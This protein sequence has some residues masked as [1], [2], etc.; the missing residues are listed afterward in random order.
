MKNR[1]NKIVIAMALAIALPTIGYSE[2]NVD[3]QDI[4][5]SKKE[6]LV[7]NAIFNN[8]LW[9]THHSI[10]DEIQQ[11]SGGTFLSRILTVFAN[12]LI[13]EIA[14][15]SGGYIDPNYKN[16]IEAESKRQITAIIVPRMEE[17]RARLLAEGPAQWYYGDVKNINNKVTEERTKE[18]N[19]I[20][21]DILFTSDK[22]KVNRLLRAMGELN[23]RYKEEN[24]H[25]LN[26]GDESKQ[27]CK[28]L[29]SETDTGQ[30]KDESSSG[31]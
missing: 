31:S 25:L 2:K 20:L 14:L 27:V 6:E 22:Q 11:E 23:E 1:I 13:R 3:V 18:C 26:K 4:F 9:I 29:C 12:Q 21:K 10:S 24:A 15:K 17:I 28:M 7:K 16:A 19:A 30:G 5:K 8:L